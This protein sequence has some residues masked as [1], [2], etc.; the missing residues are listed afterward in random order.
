[1]IDR[2]KLLHS[3]QE[4]R[5]E[6]EELISAILV[7]QHVAQTTDSWTDVAN[8][9]RT[10]YTWTLINDEWQLLASSPYCSL[11]QGPSR[12]E[13]LAHDIK[14]FIRQYKLTG[15]VTALV[16]YCEPSMTCSGRQLEKYGV[17]QHHGCAAH[18]LEST[19][20]KVFTGEAAAACLNRCRKTVARFTGSSQAQS[21]LMRDC[22]AQGPQI[23]RL[24]VMQ[25]VV[26]RW[27]SAHDMGERLTV[28][29]P[30]I[31]NWY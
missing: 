13:G 7:G 23:A 27:W 30:A 21:R 24:A 3:L 31:Q 11:A 26:T 8:R 1:M 28:L 14:A 19:A 6:L 20:G 17:T 10:G 18:R 9:T 2:R 15:R 29:G 12:G 4:I 22:E 25:D 16:S 5:E